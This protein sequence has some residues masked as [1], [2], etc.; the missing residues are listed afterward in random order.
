MQL[1]RDT[2][3]DINVVL[4]YAPGE[5]R[6]R[7]RVLR[8]SAIVT[9]DRIVDWPIAGLAQLSTAALD[10]VLELDP[11]IVLLSTGAV[12][13]FPEPAAY[14]H[15]NARGVGFEVMAL[16]AAC[17]TYNLLLADERRVALALLA[18]D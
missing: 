1:T 14:A 11:E 16:G 15:V 18:G 4:G 8:T 9:R 13:R 6:L 17:R 2:R 10:R 3:T 7:D 5:V 12:Q